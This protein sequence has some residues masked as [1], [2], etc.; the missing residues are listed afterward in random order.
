VAFG[1]E[2]DPH[3]MIAWA[4]RS[5]RPMDPPGDLHASPLAL[6]TDVDLGPPDVLAAFLEMTPH[7]TEHRRD[8]HGIPRRFFV[9]YE[10]TLIWPLICDFAPPEGF[11]PSHTV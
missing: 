7:D 3:L 5:V 6:A 4:L 2:L 9:V 11:E 8:S 1:V 10:V